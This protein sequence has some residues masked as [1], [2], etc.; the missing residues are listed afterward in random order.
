MKMYHLEVY[1]NEDGNISIKQEDEYE[2]AHIILSPEQIEPFMVMLARTI[3][4]DPIPE[5]D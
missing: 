1:K 2:D 3:K 5:K 4:K